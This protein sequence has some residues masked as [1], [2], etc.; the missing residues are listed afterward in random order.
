M[1]SEIKEL[2]RQNAAWHKANRETKKTTP[3][4]IKVFGYSIPSSYKAYGISKIAGFDVS[5]NER[6]QDPSTNALGEFS[7]IALVRR[8]S[9]KNDFLK[10]DGQIVG[11][12]SAEAAQDW[13]DLYLNGEYTVV[14]CA[15]TG[16]YYNVVPHALVVRYG[17]I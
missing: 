3:V 1:N 4:Q 10:S 6:R 9:V 5:S 11:F 7:G 15:R 12:A 13:N 8:L 2:S 16:S 17:V 14:H